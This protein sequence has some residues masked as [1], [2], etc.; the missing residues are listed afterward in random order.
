MNENKYN[1]SSECLPV[2]VVCRVYFLKG[3]PLLF[4]YKFR[5]GSAS[6]NIKNSMYILYYHC[7]IRNH[8]YRKTQGIVS[9]GTI[10]IIKHKE[11]F[12]LVPYL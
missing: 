5:N 9:P 6:V 10:F 1:V 11:L 4:Y 3:F 2:P 8:V 12:N 7:L